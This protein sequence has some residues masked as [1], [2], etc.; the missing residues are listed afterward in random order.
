MDATI[1]WLFSLEGFG[2]FLTCF[3][4]LMVFSFLYRDN[5]FYKFAEH[6]F[7]GTST[8]YGIV[9]VYFQ[10]LK[11]NLIERLFPSVDK[12]RLDLFRAGEVTAA[13]FAEA[14]VSAG[15]R[16]MHGEWI[17]YIFL[18]LGIMMLLKVT[19]RYHWVARWPLAYVIGAFAGIQIIQ[20]TQGSLIPQLEATMKDFSGQGEVVIALNESGFF[21]D[22][23]FD[24]RLATLATDLT[25]WQ[26]TYEADASL[27][28]ALRDG[29]LAGSMHLLQ[30]DSFKDAPREALRTLRSETWRLVEEVPHESLYCEF[31]GG[32]P[33]A[34]ALELSTFGDSDSAEQEWA[35]LSDEGLEKDLRQHLDLACLPF[36]NLA[37]WQSD[38]AYLFTRIRLESPGAKQSF[39]LGTPLFSPPADFYRP[40]SRASLSEL[41]KKEALDE[42]A[43]QDFSLAETQHLVDSLFTQT[44]NRPVMPHEWSIE[45]LLNLKERVLQSGDLLSLEDDLQLRLLNI[46]PKDHPATLAFWQRSLLSDMK[47]FRQLQ[48]QAALEKFTQRRLDTA[49][50]QAQQQSFRADPAV[51]MADAQYDTKALKWRILVEIISNLLVVI[52][53]CTG[54]IYFFFSKKHTG[55][56][57]VASKVGIAFLMMSFGASFGYT[58][59][60]RISLAIGRFQDLLAFPWMAGTA[61]VVLVV[62]LILEARRVKA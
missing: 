23:E 42:G 39:E 33:M 20:A 50:S 2:A 44:N 31:Y 28:G 24:T 26:S 13:D 62:A 9:L 25:A 21:P 17:Y 57:G 7:V 10:V 40:T 60:G 36:V 56:L 51:F 15:M 38:L 27:S 30:G 45:Q 16:F 59:M 8:G 58:V 29:L 3:T 47:S 18:V 54:I 14:P 19:K 53:V 35:L 49:F 11:P 5:P 43:T 46:P 22:G 12:V 41:L 52:G 37:L 61:L 32:R 48:V 6:V 34:T 55:A 1:T 4:T